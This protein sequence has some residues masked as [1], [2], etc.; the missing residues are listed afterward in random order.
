VTRR[1]PPRRV[2]R[3]C[4]ICGSSSHDIRRCD[5]FAEVARHR[6]EQLRACWPGRDLAREHRFDDWDELHDRLELA[7][8]A[9]M[10]D[11]ALAFGHVE[12]LVDRWPFPPRTPECANPAPIAPAWFRLLIR[13]HRELE[14]ALALEETP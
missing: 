12:N 10:L 4:S 3:R 7:I 1:P 9:T 2:P 6:L 8:D 5:R 11:V 14:L 13:A